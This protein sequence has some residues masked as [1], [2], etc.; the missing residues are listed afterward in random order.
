ML[1]RDLLNLHSITFRYI[2]WKLSTVYNI[3]NISIYMILVIYLEQISINTQLNELRFIWTWTHIVRTKNQW[4]SVT[5]IPI[6]HS[7]DY[8]TFHYK[9]YVDQK[10]RNNTTIIWSFVYDRNEIENL[11]N[12]ELHNGLVK[13]SQLSSTLGRIVT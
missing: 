1:M 2:S 7:N 3:C 5:L 10:K 6:S 11:A 8:F 13:H 9:I 12:F 4:T